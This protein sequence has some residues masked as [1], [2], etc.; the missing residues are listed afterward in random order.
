MEA[1][2]SKKQIPLC[3][4]PTWKYVKAV[5]TDIMKRFRSMGWTPP[6]ELKEAKDEAKQ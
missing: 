5:E 1:I 2:E 4:D 3:F 6:S